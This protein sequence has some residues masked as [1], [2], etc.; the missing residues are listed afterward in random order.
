[1]PLMLIPAIGGGTPRELLKVDAPSRSAISWTPDARWLI[2]SARE[3]AE[4]PFGIWRVSAET[5]EHYPVLPRPE[6][7]PTGLSTWEY[8]DTIASL[9]PDGRVLV[10]ARS[11]S[12]YIFNLYTVRLT[13]DLRPEGTPRKLTDQTYEN[14]GGFAWANEREIIFSDMGPNGGLLRIRVSGETS[15]RRLNW[16]AGGDFP[17]IAR[18]QHRLAYVQARTNE[19]LW[20]RDLRTG[21]ERMIVGPDY[22]QQHPQY[23]PDGRRIAFEADRSGPHGVW[24]CDADGENCQEITSFAGTFGGAPRWSPDGR[25]LAFDSRAD[26]KSQIYVIPSDGGAQRRVTTSTADDVVPS[27]SRDGRWIYFMSDRSGKFRIWKTPVAGGEAVQV[28]FAEGGAAFESN[29]GKY[30]YFSSEREGGNALFRMSV[31][32]GGV[33]QVLPAVLSWSSFSVTAKGVYFLSDPQTLRL[34][35]E[36]NGQI[37]TVAKLQ[38]HPVGSEGITVSPDGAYLVFADQVTGRTN[39]ML[40]EG[41]R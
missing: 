10:F 36:V 6:K 38:G 20:R 26:G 2:I 11:L 7:L 34:L 19:D 22:N 41:F 29:D 5:G 16:A 23:S 3:S 15:P 8:G 30:L 39:L 31:G 24:T 28:T 18:S 1:M 25:W 33:K 37:R 17:A 14:I 13:K 21:D 35:D 9:S 4:E 40:V 12:T 32:G 27:W